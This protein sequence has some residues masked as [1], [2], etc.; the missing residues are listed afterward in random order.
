MV[1]E[2]SQF[3]NICLCVTSRIS[4][5]PP[6][7]ETLDIPTLSTE[8]ARD[9][10]HQ[11]YKNG[12]QSNLVNSILQ[13]LDFHPLSITLLATVAHHNKWDTKQL[14]REWKRQR[15]G[16][17]RTEHN[18]SLSA[19]IEL[20]LA[21]P[22]FRKLGPD[23]RG[24]L[25]VVAFFPQGVD[26][27]N[28]DWLFPTISD[29]RHIFNKFCILSLTHRSNGLIT[30]L[31][32]LRDHLSPKDPKSSPLLCMT[33]GYYFSRLSVGAYPGKP[34]YEEARWIT[35]EDVNVEHLLDIFTSIDAN[36]D[37]VWEACRSFTEHLYWHKPRLVVLGQKIEELP[38]DRPSKPECLYQLSW[39][40]QSVGNHAENKR[41]LAHALRLWRERRDD[42]RVAQTLSFLAGTNRMLYLKAEGILQVKEA[43]EIFKRLNDAL[44]QA[45]S[46]KRLAWLLLED[47]QPSAAEVAASRAI[48]LF[49]SEGEEFEV[50]HCH[51]VLGYICYSKG[52]KK[53]AINHLQTALRTASSLNW[54]SMEFLIL[55]S[56][57]DLSFNQ[58]RFEDAH[59]H[60][61]R[62]K[63]RAVNDAHDLGLAMLLQANIWYEQRRLEEAKSEALHAV[64]V[65]LE[66]GAANN[67]GNCERILQLIEEDELA[68]T[69]QTG[70]R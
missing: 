29:R 6:T 39:L 12:R 2:L 23:A 14:A 7:C 32:P 62:A 10:F 36:S 59:A 47:D 9:T 55:Y 21:S 40:F 50:C 28:L 4:T 20:S 8:A 38:D 61:E 60:I 70:G 54:H 3:G 13:Q 46:L 11:I 5:V 43:L 66:L 68:V 30:T 53:E 37:D 48:N 51:R 31:A 49:S 69:S 41:L 65:F 1:E 27:N 44:G 34:G 24:L 19:T 58:G 25:G 16:V 17:L 56:L 15:T 67:V 45:H 33:K 18:K 35:S 52:E 22:M 64:C 42:A 26:E 57:A 63:Q